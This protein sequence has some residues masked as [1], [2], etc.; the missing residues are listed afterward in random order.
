[1]LR[2]LLDE[3]WKSMLALLGRVAAS[4]ALATALAMAGSGSL[5]AQS[6]VDVTVADQNG[7]GVPFAVIWTERTRPVIAD[8]LGRVRM[9]LRGD[10]VFLQV[11]RIGYRE[12][13]GFVRL[14]DGRAAVTLPALALAMDTVRI[15]E[16]VISP[17]ERRGFYDRVERVKR[18]AI[19]G[20]FFAPEEVALRDV[21][22]VSDLLR[23]S[24]YV[25]V[26]MTSGGARVNIPVMLGRGGCAMT[27]LVDGQQMKG[28]AQDNVTEE[29]PTSINRSGRTGQSG[30]GTASIDDIVNGRSVQAVEVY[31]STA[32]APAELQT[33]GG[34]GSCGIIAIWTGSAQ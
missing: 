5:A 32:N 11:R 3:T 29:T 16:R 13:R 25:R 18:G 34:R 9:A 6:A 15:V 21:A 23:G 20:E 30:G 19:V 33:L 4:V 10:S 12:F 22:N 24:R 27:I 17:L 7:R 26:G 28:T 2:V 8:S 1:M 14:A 31:P